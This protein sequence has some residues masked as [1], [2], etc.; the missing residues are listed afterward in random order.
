MVTEN[1]FSCSIT[2]FSTPLVVGGEQQA[3][4][5]TGAMK[6][7]AVCICVGLI[8]LL[9]HNYELMAKLMAKLMRRVQSSC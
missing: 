3:S 7:A 4:W 9:A 1:S 8:S 2:G 6:A 5:H